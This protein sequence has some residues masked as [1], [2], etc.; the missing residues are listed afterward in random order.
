MLS[1]SFFFYSGLLGFLYT[2]KGPDDA[3]GNF[4]IQDQRL[5]LKW[6]QENIANFGGDPNKVCTCT[7]RLYAD[8]CNFIINYHLSG[9]VETMPYPRRCV[10]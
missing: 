1:Q 4:G 3:H 9:N 2:G 6:V 7:K 5:A 8:I 10:A